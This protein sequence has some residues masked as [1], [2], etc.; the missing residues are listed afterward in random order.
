MDK[1]YLTIGILV[2]I[3]I[4][5]NGYLITRLNTEPIIEI[6][7]VEKEQPMLLV[8]FNSW[9]PSEEDSSNSLFD[10]FIYNF[11]DIEAKD[12]LIRCDV[13]EKDNGEIVKSQ[14]YNIGNVASNS[15]SWEQNKMKYKIL[16]D[17]TIVAGCYLEGASGDYLDL[18]SKIKE[19]Y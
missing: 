1:K 2:L 6:K 9:G 14:I 11:G 3:L 12:V 18:D 5:S 17:G 13:E 4:L 16:H 8:Y 7:E 15:Y 10:Y 19:D